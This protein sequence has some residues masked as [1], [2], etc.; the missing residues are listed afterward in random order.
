MKQATTVP[1][2]RQPVTAPHVITPPRP[3]VSQT[4]LAAIL[5]VRRDVKEA[6]KSLKALKSYLAEKEQ[7]V[8]QALEV[9]AVVSHGILAAEVKHE[10][11]RNVAWRRVAE[12]Y[13]GADFCELVVEETPATVYPRLVIA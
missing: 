7:A 10:E 4:S 5:R 12:D 8:I 9:G 2:N 11:R 6:E 1:T 13:L 3:A